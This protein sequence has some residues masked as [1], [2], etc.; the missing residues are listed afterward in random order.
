MPQTYKEY[1]PSVFDSAAN[2]FTLDPEGIAA[3][4][5]WLVV[6]APLTRDADVLSESNH[7][8]ILAALGGESEAVQVKEFGHWACGWYRL[9]LAHPSLAARVAE[10][11]DAL[12]AYP[13]WD[14]DDFSAR[15]TRDMDAAWDD[16]GARQLAKDLQACFDLSDEA[17]DLLVSRSNGALYMF[18]RD[19][20]HGDY[21][22]NSGASF[23]FSYLE[24]ET[25]RDE[26]AALLHQCRKESK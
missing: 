9:V 19:H 14:E 18:H 26:V 8:S 5:D 4:A 25:T 24:R 3:I 23:D 12:G 13:V 7:Y 2:F 20:T 22:D 16:W 15:E 6:P 17:T 11:E 21:C 10:I 1:Q